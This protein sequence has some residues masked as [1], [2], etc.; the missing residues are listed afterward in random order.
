MSEPDVPF[1]KMATLRNIAAFRDALQRLDLSLPCDETL[2]TGAE[3]SLARPLTAHH[4]GVMQ[5]AGLVRVRL[6]C[7]SVRAE[8]LEALR[9]YFDEAL[10]AA[11][12]SSPNA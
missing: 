4:L 12:I 10:T 2:A 8:Q 5:R 1:V 9:R 7:A 3:S 11:A 6:R